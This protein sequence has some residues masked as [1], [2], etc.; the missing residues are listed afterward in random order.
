MIQHLSVKNR[1]METQHKN[2]HGTKGQHLEG[3]N[4]FYKQCALQE[5]ELKYCQIRLKGQC[6]LF[7]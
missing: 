1:H 4:K 3:Y 7:L 6:N 2:E 5:R